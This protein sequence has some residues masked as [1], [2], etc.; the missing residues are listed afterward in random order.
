MRAISALSASEKRSQASAAAAP[1]TRTSQ[2]AQPP[3]HL[4]GERLAV[5]NVHHHVGAFL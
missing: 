4:L 5:L 1:I 3:A 2:K